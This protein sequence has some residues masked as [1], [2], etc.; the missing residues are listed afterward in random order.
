MLRGLWLHAGTGTGK[1][2]ITPVSHI[3]DGACCI[4]HLSSLHSTPAI[5]S[6]ANIFRHNALVVDLPSTTRY[7][8]VCVLPQGEARL[9]G[10]SQPGGGDQCLQPAARDCRLPVLAIVERDGLCAASAKWWSGPRWQLPFDG[11]IMCRLHPQRFHDC[12]MMQRPGAT[13]LDTRCASGAVLSIQH[14][15]SAE[16]CGTVR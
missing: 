15:G 16:P 11:S 2:H 14:T 5:R 12:R 8:R 9:P 6:I 13:A 7:A 1:T 4:S 10:Q 3:A